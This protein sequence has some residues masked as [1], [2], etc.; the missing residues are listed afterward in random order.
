M[1]VNKDDFPYQQFVEDSLGLDW[2]ELQTAAGEDM[3]Y[4]NQ[5]LY[6]RAINMRIKEHKAT[7]KVDEDEAIIRTEAEMEGVRSHLGLPD[8]VPYE[9][10]LKLLNPESFQSYLASQQLN[11]NQQNSTIEIAVDDYI[12]NISN[13][14][15]KWKY[16][17][18]TSSTKKFLKERMLANF[19]ED[20]GEF[21]TAKDFLA[22]QFVTIEQK[23][24]VDTAND[25]SNEGNDTSANDDGTSIFDDSN[26]S[27][28][29]AG[30]RVG[31]SLA[32]SLQRSWVNEDAQDAASRIANPNN[33]QYIDVVGSELPQMQYVDPRPNIE[34]AAEDMLE[35]WEARK[36]I[37]DDP[38]MQELMNAPDFGS[39]LNKF[40]TNPELFPKII[41]E[42]GI[43]IVEEA[44]TQMLVTAAGSIGSPVAGVAAG[45]V[46]SAG[47]A[48]ENA[49]NAFF[50]QQVQKYIEEKN[51]PL[52][53]ESILAFYDD[54]PA[55]NKARED[56]TTSSNIIS[57]A[58]GAS[59][60]VGGYLAI[61][62]A[63]KIAARAGYKPV[64]KSGELAWQRVTKGD[65]AARYATG[66]LASTV[67]DTGGE[68]ASK[69]AVDE[70]VKPGELAANIIVG[71][72][73]SVADVASGGIAGGG[74][75][76]VGERAELRI[77]DVLYDVAGKGSVVTGTDGYN[78][79]L[80][81]ADGITE[82]S[83]NE[84]GSTYSVAAPIQSVPETSIDSDAVVPRYVNPETTDTPQA[85]EYDVPAESKSGAYILDGAVTAIMHRDKGA[86]PV[87]PDDLVGALDAEISRVNGGS[88]TESLKTVGD[89]VI[90][91]T[92]GVLKDDAN[93]VLANSLKPLTYK[94][95]SGRYHP[96][97]T[98]DME[99]D[100][101][102]A[103]AWAAEIVN[104]AELRGK[105]NPDR[106]KRKALSAVVAQNVDATDPLNNFGVN[107]NDPQAKIASGQSRDAVLNPREQAI[108]LPYPP[109]AYS[110]PTREQILANHEATTRGLNESINSIQ[111]DID[112]AES[113]QDFTRAVELLSEK[114]AT[115]TRIREIEFQKLSVESTEKAFEFYAKQSS[116]LE[117]RIAEV[118]KKIAATNDPTEAL[119]IQ[120]E[121]DSLNTQKRKA[122]FDYLS[123][124][125]VALS[126][127]EGQQFVG[128]APFQR[129]STENPI[130]L[131]L[132]RLVT[133][134]KSL[135]SDAE[136]ALDEGNEQALTEILAKKDEVDQD[137][138]EALEY[139]KQQAGVVD[140]NPEK[141]V[142]PKAQASRRS[143][144]D[145]EFLW[146]LSG[147]Y[148]SFAGD[149]G[150]LSLN[151]DGRLYFYGQN[152]SKLLKTS[153]VVGDAEIID[154]D[155][156]AVYGD[157]APIADFDSNTVELDGKTYSYLRVNTNEGAL[158]SV[159]LA[160]EQGNEITFDGSIAHEIE[161]QKVQYE[162][163]QNYSEDEQI[164]AIAAVES[165][166]TIRPELT[167]GRDEQPGSESEDAGGNASPERP[168]QAATEPEVTQT[169]PDNEFVAKARAGYEKAKAE[170]E[171][172]KKE[173]PK[174]K[175]FETASVTVTK[176]DGK[177]FAR[178]GDATR[179]MKRQGIDGT[180]IKKD[181]GY[182]AVAVP[183]NPDAPAEFSELADNALPRP[184]AE[185]ADPAPESTGKLQ[186][187]EFVR[188]QPE[189]SY[190]YGDKESNYIPQETIDAIRSDG[191]E[192]TEVTNDNGS[193]KGIK[194]KVGDKVAHI[195]SRGVD[196]SDEF[197]DR[198]F[199]VRIKG[200]KLRK[201]GG[202]KKFTIPAEHPP[203][204]ASNTPA[205]FIQSVE[206]AAADAG[207]KV[208]SSTDN[209]MRTI[210]KNGESHVIRN[211]G[212]QI[213][214]DDKPMGEV[215]G[216]AVTPV[217][218]EE[219]IKAD[220]A[221]QN[222]AVKA[223]HTLKNPAPKKETLGNKQNRQLEQEL[224]ELDEEFAATPV[225]NTSF[226]SIDVGGTI[227]LWVGGDPDQTIRDARLD[228]RVMNT[229]GKGRTD[230]TE[231]E[232]HE[233]IARL[234]EHIQDIISLQ[235]THD[236]EL[237]QTG[238]L[239]SFHPDKNGN[240]PSIEVDIYPKKGRTFE[241]IISTISEE[242]A[243]FSFENWT[244]GQSLKDMK[245]F[246][247]KAFRYYRGQIE[248]SLPQYI[249]RENVDMNNPT[250]WQQYVLVNEMF[251]KQGTSFMDL[252]DNKASRPAG[253]TDDELADIKQAGRKAVNSFVFDMT[254]NGNPDMTDAKFFAEE[255]LRAQ[256]AVAAGGQTVF[257][258][259]VDRGGRTLRIIP[260]P[261]G[262]GR[263][264][265]PVSKEGNR[266]K[267]NINRAS[268]SR[269]WELFYK[270]L[271][272]G[273]ELMTRQISRIISNS[274]GLDHARSKDLLQKQY[275]KHKQIAAILR[276]KGIEIDDSTFLNGVRAK[277][278]SLG[279]KDKRRLA[280]A[281]EADESLAVGQDAIIRNAELI[282]NKI[283]DQ[284][285]KLRRYG[286]N[287]DPDKLADMMAELKE[288][289]KKF[290][291][292]Y[293]HRRYRA[294]EDPAQKKI[295]RDMLN[296]LEGMP[297]KKGTLLQQKEAAERE[298]RRINASDM[299]ETQKRKAII[300]QE[301][302]KSKYD[303]LVS[304]HKM[305][306]YRSD[307]SKEPYTNQQYVGKV[308]DYL[309]K[310]L[311]QNRSGIGG[312]FTKIE[313]ISSTRAAH[314]D[315]D[316]GKFTS[317]Y[318]EIQFL[319]PITDPIENMIFSVQ[320]QKEVLR[321]L[322]ANELLA[323][324]LVEGL[325]GD[326][327]YIDGDIDIQESG[328][329]FLGLGQAGSIL[330]YVRV[331]PA[332]ARNMEDAIKA[333]SEVNHNIGHNLVSSIKYGQ[334]V[335]NIGTHAANMLGV[336]SMVVGS[337]H[338]IYLNQ[339]LNASKAVRQAWVQRTTEVNPLTGGNPIEEMVK[340]MYDLRVLGS[341]LQAGT[342]E[343]TNKTTLYQDALK[344]LSKAIGKGS[345]EAEIRVGTGIDNT[346]KFIQ[347]LYT[348]SDEMPKLLGYM[349][350]KD[351]ALVKWTAK[352][353]RQDFDTEAEYKLALNEAVKRE[354]AD[355]TL[356][357]A[358][359][360]GVSADIVKSMAL[361]NGR[362][363]IADYIMHHSQMLKI[364]TENFRI[365]TEEINDWKEAVAGGH[366]EWA[367]SVG[368]AVA[369]RTVG[370][371]AVVGGLGYTA[372]TGLSLVA[373]A[374]NAGMEQ[375]GFVDED[376]YLD[377]DQRKGAHKLTLPENYDGAV[378][379]QPL[380]IKDGDYFYAVNTMRANN[381]STFSVIPTLSTEYEWSEVVGNTIKNAVFGGA[382]ETITGQIT[383]AA[384]GYDWKGDQV[385]SGR[386]LENFLNVSRNFLTPG[387]AK[388]ASEVMSGEKF[389]TN[390][391][392]HGGEFVMTTL[393]MTMKKF[394]LP[395]QITKMAYKANRDLR[396]RDVTSILVSELKGGSKSISQEDI[397][398]RVKQD[399][400]TNQKMMREYNGMVAAWTV[401]LG[402]SKAELAK[403]LQF[404][405]LENKKTNFR[406][407]KQI[408]NGI[409]IFSNAS[410]KKLQKELAN[411]R[412]KPVSQS[413][414]K[415][416]KDRAIKNTQYAIEQYKL[417]M[418][419]KQ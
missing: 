418:K 338:A 163:E 86:L 21:T 343:V 379:Y 373:A 278:E 170:A 180:V 374:V 64:M 275:T 298:I 30:R 186:K 125:G 119:K 152:G 317:D 409:D 312:N 276:G 25:A 34:I 303:R 333:H 121:L 330:K 244:T 162:I 5:E 366:T 101:I 267:R 126:P 296:E 336:A 265:L 337:G 151:A 46:A 192:V 230:Y 344:G 200:R 137:I 85:F 175:G 256:T 201:Y 405:K 416:R 148:V 116:R 274:A 319:Q 299:S 252:V 391:E 183:K 141:Q 23:S 224:N 215:A 107:P 82:I 378:N 245:T 371:A 129:S 262:Q 150:Y 84:V 397:L 341:G 59:S 349:I 207:F 146:E 70:E 234:P 94:D 61:G 251:S 169:E 293:I 145:A 220:I 384:F 130:D 408:I 156:T 8:R 26:F 9:E 37:G 313:N 176:K 131:A 112:A 239:G 257:D 271:P 269:I 383:K 359:D 55:Y 80:S 174:Q 98:P 20:V 375:L 253:L 181:G 212:G 75:N 321:A 196:N 260:T 254:D 194:V 326:I 147:S 173:A 406:H 310:M 285:E 2:N 158:E 419:A 83:G 279:I 395:S 155:F 372:M 361:N 73:M 415:D 16:P 88:F 91:D 193:I 368:K 348:M 249:S 114:Q 19:P 69:V 282:R 143:P 72:G 108:P 308:K 280:L 364:T 246:Y 242:V 4:V 139:F 345:E 50:E 354:A 417:Q 222:E 376:D 128:S 142:E 331:H 229:P 301:D 240:G 216:I 47:V 266:L 281:D 367:N 394:H 11:E 261:I 33:T 138:N 199:N 164:S 60:L 268:G 255:I 347:D 287:V 290:R 342:L 133:E 15:N 203:I 214:I 284:V 92:D 277:F 414:P 39:A 380:A 258:M 232:I 118:E 99:G 6:G 45:S 334:T 122:D 95:D 211:E 177:P 243:H 38:V 355:K 14:D 404:N 381:F 36:A 226:S 328:S 48:K 413:F 140:I 159:V 283:Y 35:A 18:L 57:A 291:S 324:E 113:S 58:A 79:T 329:D 97:I 10:Q 110:V 399:I 115:E 165:D 305:F 195:N 217:T 68:I 32:P 43:D 62:T 22:K 320:Q 390:K 286:A 407:A 56:A 63:A 412:A 325:G 332:L 153:D 185:V 289:A 351:K 76:V 188:M 31:E 40:I 241:S 300:K 27:V 154:I 100:Q 322:D 190:N 393:G 7:P 402:R 29:N 53:K 365:I 323:K 250:S 161:S 294:Y 396:K 235:N 264:V 120:E 178:K 172:A 13:K 309:R 411:V 187:T 316:A 410:M 221:K 127:V 292:D 24:P 272:W 306:H 350:E 311:D 124:S 167:P 327:A 297:D 369:A 401:D 52:T 227:R 225:G 197:K 346:F 385:A 403:H 358:T 363:V 210:T 71:A 103:R 93:R 179:A 223:E 191:Y 315:H 74:G 339:Y 105:G 360:W 166:K 206:D 144:E 106:I 89:A 3:Q 208:I 49:Y 273:N 370:N 236:S 160:D 398:S 209:S 388:T 386:K 109:D 41:A 357:Q 362:F 135:E 295:F 66:A 259:K 340:E 204:V 87:I 382:G 111:R 335:L 168:E 233:Y 213:F 352:M 81:G 238:R 132:G 219:A 247:D 218:K 189:R 78:V 400:K 389:I 353:S 1:P 104:Y 231:A 307:R 356:R 263:N 44:G 42:N 248:G 377:A 387:I 28:F 228:S 237:H 102:Q 198:R 65:V 54:K 270:N 205:E 202:N 134:S 136:R 17:E 184:K 302:I 314:L 123:T 171:A 12:S 288:S 157:T 77:G 67:I 304:L 318:H 90:W 96:V 392:L 117:S 182:I 51:L 149:E